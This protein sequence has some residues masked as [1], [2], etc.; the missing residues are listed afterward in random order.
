VPNPPI[1]VSDRALPPLP[2]AFGAERGEDGVWRLPEMKVELASP[3]AALHLGP[4]NVVLEAAAME[5]VAEHA[6]T[7]ALQVESWT[8]MMIRPGVVGPFRAE[9]EIV[10]GGSERM[11]TQ[12][13]LRDEGKDDRVISVASAVFRRV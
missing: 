3:H 2:A 13:T 4:I 8:V 1:E 6:G 12:L 5:R 11:A 7:D 10:S 9:A